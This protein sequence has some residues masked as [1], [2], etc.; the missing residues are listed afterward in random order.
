MKDYN[1]ILRIRNIL[2]K[3]SIHLQKVTSAGS[4]TI[5]T[6]KKK[7]NNT[8]STSPKT[9]RTRRIVSVNAFSEYITLTRI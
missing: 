7:A 4:K 2:K 9:T 6:S 5:R 3:S 8:V 1:L